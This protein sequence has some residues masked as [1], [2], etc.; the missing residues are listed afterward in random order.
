MT[1][2]I[3]SLTSGKA[4]PFFARHAW[5]VLLGGE[6]DD[7]VVWGQRHGW[8]RC[9]S[10]KWGE[11]ILMHSLTGMSWVELQTRAQA[12]HLIEC[13][14]RN[15]GASLVTIALLSM[16]ICLTAFVKGSVG[17]GMPCGRCPCGCC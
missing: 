12:A 8:R 14:F 16:A 2:D 7:R 6:P 15:N 5:K 4:E 1:A 10:S 13:K 9:R 17:P 3:S 11:V